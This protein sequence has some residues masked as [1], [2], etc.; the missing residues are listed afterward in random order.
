QR[1]VK[2]ERQ[3]QSIK[4]A[5]FLHKHL[6][7]EFEGIISSVTKFG[8]FVLLKKFDIDGLLKLEELGMEHFDFNEDLMELVGRNSGIH[9]Q[10]G[11]SITVQVAAADVQTGRIDFVLASRDDKGDDAKTP[12]SQSAQKRR[13]TENH[14]GGLRKARVS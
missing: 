4:K 5:R 3:I 12:Q 1:S 10:L 7:K 9:Y 11:D 13:Q 6:G 14:R 8:V 2:A